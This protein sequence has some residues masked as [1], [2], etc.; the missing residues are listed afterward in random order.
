VWVEL[1]ELKTR[2][3]WREHLGKERGGG[4][5]EREEEEAKERKEASGRRR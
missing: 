2:V 1:A 4:K 3:E 5:Q